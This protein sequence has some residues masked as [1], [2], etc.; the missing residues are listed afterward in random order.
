M[1]LSP[2]VVVEGWRAVSRMRSRRRF[3]RGTL[4]NVDSW[5]DKHELLTHVVW[6]L[7]GLS[8]STRGDS[9]T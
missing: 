8:P 5:W 4:H 3:L 1:M 2:I 7:D 9:I 6:R